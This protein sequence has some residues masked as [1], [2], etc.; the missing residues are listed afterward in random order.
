MTGL[1]GEESVA[2]FSRL[3]RN[4]MRPGR[5]RKLGAARGVIVGCASATVGW[6][7]IYGAFRLGRALL[8]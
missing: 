4:E 6:G 7:L 8:Q 3:P 1:D 5:E 2:R